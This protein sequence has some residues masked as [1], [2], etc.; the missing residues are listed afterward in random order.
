MSDQVPP[1]LPR[2]ETMLVTYL[3]AFA[4]T[5]P[6]L[7]IWLFADAFLLPRLERLGI[8]PT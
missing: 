8:T 4:T 7:L 1:P 3:M 5:G 2:V 6:A